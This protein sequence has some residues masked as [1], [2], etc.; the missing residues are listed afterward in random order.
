MRESLSE[1]QTGFQELHA[2]LP[3]CWGLDSSLKDPEGDQSSKRAGAA[4]LRMPTS[5]TVTFP[6][7]LLSCQWEGRKLSGEL[8]RVNV[9]LQLDSAGHS[10]SP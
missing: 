9:R 10:R 2:A 1:G 8:P 6:H 5:S 7:L 3:L 4:N